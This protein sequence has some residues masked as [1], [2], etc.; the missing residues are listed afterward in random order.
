MKAVSNDA[1]RPTI[2]QLVGHNVRR[3]REERGITQDDVAREARAVGLAWSR[4]TVGALENGGKTLD[5]GEVVLLAAAMPAPVAQLLAP[6][7]AMLAAD[8]PFIAVGPALAMRP[9]SIL[10]ALAAS[11]V[12]D[13]GAVETEREGYLTDIDGAAHHGRLEE[14]KKRRQRHDRITGGTSSSMFA[15]AT[16][17]ARGEAEMKAARRLDVDPVELALAAL[18]LW[19]RSLTEERDARVAEATEPG[20]TPR[21]LQALRGHLTRQ[22]LKEL[23]PIVR[24]AD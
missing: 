11:T 3:I 14:A 20:A 17:A 10:A 19:G 18:K 8:D 21:T 6:S 9:E 12:R 15:Q 23:E 4:S 2:D 16:E 22:L 5:L 13:L 7:D 1:K 24:R